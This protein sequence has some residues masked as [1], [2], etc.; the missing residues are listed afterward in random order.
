MTS[1][2]VRKKTK[3]NTKARKNRKRLWMSWAVVQSSRIE[4]SL[5]QK[6]SPSL[7]YWHASHSASSYGVTV[8]KATLSFRIM[9]LRQLLDL[10]PLSFVP[11]MAMKNRNATKIRLH[12]HTHTQIKARITTRW[13]R[14]FCFG[15]SACRTRCWPAVALEPSP[16]WPAASAPA[17]AASCPPAA[18]GSGSGSTGTTRAGTSQTEKCT[19]RCP[20][21][22]MLAEFKLFFVWF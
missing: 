2:I 3:L 8:H 10:F 15:S 18:P 19:D 5:R 22:E 11:K 7:S 14:V 6:V 20:E 12:T 4:V 17:G 9:W 21:W 1:V 16:R 13:R